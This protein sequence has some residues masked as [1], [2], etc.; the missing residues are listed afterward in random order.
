M[1]TIELDEK[2]AKRL[3]RVLAS[4][5][6]DFCYSMR[7]LI[8]CIECGQPGFANDSAGVKSPKAMKHTTKAVESINMYLA[9]VPDDWY[10]HIK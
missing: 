4:D 10:D 6:R 7:E 5:R 2:D 3:A 8:Y 9:Q 1:V